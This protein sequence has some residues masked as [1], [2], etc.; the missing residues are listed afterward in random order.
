MA[1]VAFCLTLSEVGYE[2][3]YRYMRQR[4]LMPSKTKLDCLNISKVHSEMPM[5]NNDLVELFF[6]LLLL[7]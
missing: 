2:D 1:K 4:I 6:K 3:M 7:L 5:V